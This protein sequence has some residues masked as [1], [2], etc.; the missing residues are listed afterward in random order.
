MKFITCLF[1]FVVGCSL[2]LAAQDVHFSQFH[3]HPL[4]QNPA[5]TGIFRGDWRVAGILR[6][7]WRSVPVSYQTFGAAAD[8]KLLRSDRNTL[9]VG[10]QLQH[11]QAG[12]AA[13]RWAQLGL[14]AAVAHAL[15]ERQ[16]LSAGFGLSTVQRSVDI[17]GLRFK[18]QWDGDLFNPNLAT[19]ENFNQNSGF[20]PSLSGGLH[21]RLELDDDGRNAL[22]AGLGAFHLNRPK[23]NFRDDADYRLP[24]RAALS[25]GASLPAGEN[26]DVL[27][28]ALGQQMY[29]AREIVAGVGARYWLEEA[30][31]Q[32]SGGYRAG[33]ALI[34]AFQIGL[35]GWTVGLSYDVNVSNF[36][37]A[38]QNRGGFELG[39]VY[40]AQPVPPVKNLKVC[41][42]F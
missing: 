19:K 42:L 17:S 11:D 23:V 10:L 29:A 36:D 34:P 4:H 37:I 28:F 41:P 26:F 12:D 38:T 2:R 15:T 40:Q 25:I 18:N 5:Q 13:L 9:S 3:L 1:L 21:W 14:T 6:S 33:D 24:V 32:F 27:A 30:Y 39:V 31:V 16:T 7:Q 20:A 35:G 8:L 22:Y